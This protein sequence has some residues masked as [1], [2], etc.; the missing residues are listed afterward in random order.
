MVLTAEVAGTTP[1][2]MIGQP[3]TLASVRNVQKIVENT[4]MELEEPLFLPIHQANFTL[5]EHRFCA[6]VAIYGRT[7]YRPR[8][9][10]RLLI[11]V[12]DEPAGGL[13]LAHPYDLIVANRDTELVLLPPLLQADPTLVGDRLSFDSVIELVESLAR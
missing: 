6:E 2:F 12:L 13:L 1:G 10:D 11:F 9:G 8:T 7:I 3:N 4:T 5:D